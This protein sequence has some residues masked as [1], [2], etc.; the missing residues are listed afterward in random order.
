MARRNGEW[1][2]RGSG[3]TEHKVLFFV[4]GDNR[5]SDW[6]MSATTESKNATEVCRQCEVVITGVQGTSD[7]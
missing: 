4:G 1:F 7:A 5:G 6:L 2:W 3:P